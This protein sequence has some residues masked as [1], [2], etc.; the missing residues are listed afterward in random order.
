MRCMVTGGAGFIGGHLAE[1]LVAEGHE[2]SVVD[3][4]STGRRDNAPDA[5]KL[6]EMDINAP[7]L[8]GVFEEARPEI[9]FHQAAQVNVRK[10]V[11]DP[12]FDARQNILGSINLLECAKASGVR[13]IVYA[14]SGGACYGE[15]E[16]LPADEDTPI[17]PLC[18]YGAS[19]Y[20]VE[21][22]VE[23]YGRLYG[24]DYTVLR[25]ANVYGPR[26][27]PHGE[28]G[29]VAIFSELLL[30]GNRPRIFGDGTKT[31]DYVFVKDV[32]EANILSMDKGSGGVY[33]VG[34]GQRTTDT[35]IYEAVRAAT[36]ARAEA[37]Y[38]DFRPGEV[39]HICLDNAR[40]RRE[41]GWA[42]TVGFAQGVEEAVA[43]YRVKL[44]MT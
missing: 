25:Y 38:E 15:P 5:A 31:R 8:S 4:L 42:P 40:I 44:G 35:D 9:V 41:L 2:V 3:N 39:K 12:A 43:F 17:R 30:Q 14:S 20:T 33:N 6:H 27:D 28:A 11:E 18:Q 24:L 13:K 19:K 34:T 21:K 36:G 37:I 29:V 32:V 16:T 1:R 10:S 23:L 7:A 26:Q 22:Y